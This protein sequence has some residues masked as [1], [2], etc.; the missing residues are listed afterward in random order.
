MQDSE[1]DAINLNLLCSPPSSLPHPSHSRGCQPRRSLL[2][3]S[4]A[5]P[6]ASVLSLGH[7]PLCTSDLRGGKFSH[8]LTELTDVSHRTEAAVRRQAVRI[9]TS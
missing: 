1:S 6:V 9:K 4:K 7:Q 8:I 2:S 3:P 5:L